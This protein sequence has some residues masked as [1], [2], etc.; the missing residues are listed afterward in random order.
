[1]SSVYSMGIRQRPISPKDGIIDGADDEKANIAHLH[2]HFYE[3]PL[4][5]SL[6][7]C[8]VLL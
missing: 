2:D 8:L 7:A 1:M 4:F 5:E 6:G 3:A